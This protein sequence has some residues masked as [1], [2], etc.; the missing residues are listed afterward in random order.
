VRKEKRDS[1][2][3][4]LNTQIGLEGTKQKQKAKETPNCHCRVRFVSLSLSL[5]TYSTR[6]PPQNKKT[7]G[8]LINQLVQ[9]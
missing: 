1:I 5:P 8:L 9:S 6:G 7:R 3:G 4:K 2:K